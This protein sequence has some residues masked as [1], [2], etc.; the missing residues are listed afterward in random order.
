VVLVDSGG[1]NDG[2]SVCFYMD[3]Q[4]SGETAV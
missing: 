3:F 2:C 1:G 4:Y